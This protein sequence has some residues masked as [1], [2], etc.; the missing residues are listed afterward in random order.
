MLL[1]RATVKL[2]EELNAEQG[3][4]EDL[5]P[6]SLPS[7]E[8]ASFDPVKPHSDV[9][10]LFVDRR[11]S[12]LGPL[13]AQLDAQSWKANVDPLHG[14]EMFSVCAHVVML[15]MWPHVVTVLT[16]CQSFG[17]FPTLASFDLD[18]ITN[19]LGDLVALQDLSLT[20]KRGAVMDVKITVQASECWHV[21]FEERFS[22]AASYAELSPS[23]YRGKTLSAS[24]LDWAQDMSTLHRAHGDLK[25]L[26]QSL[27]REVVAECV[28]KSQGSVSNIRKNLRKACDT[29]AAPLVTFATFSVV[30]E[31]VRVCVSP[32]HHT[33]TY[34]RRVG[35]D[36]SYARRAQRGG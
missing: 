13:D 23:L 3:D 5:V 32:V 35:R 10:A 17:A 33:P 36:L 11:K 26:Q 7:V 16:L 29:R 34:P 25:L 22:N 21:R 12:D 14:E 19:G 18:D 2:I 31:G 6:F 4:A 8:E 15:T 1:N 9:A 27:A 24:T 20:G 28:T 30:T